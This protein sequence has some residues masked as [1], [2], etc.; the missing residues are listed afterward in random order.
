MRLFLPYDLARLQT[1][2]LK[3]SGWVNTFEFYLESKIYKI[4]RFNFFSVTYLPIHVFWEY[5]FCVNL[6][7]VNSKFTIFL[8]I[9]YRMIRKNRELG[10]K[11]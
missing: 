2:M 3:I 8:T 1:I 9:H 11:L 5:E 6:K 10:G 7:S 4:F